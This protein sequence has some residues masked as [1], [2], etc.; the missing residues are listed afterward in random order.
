MAE[1]IYKSSLQAR[2]FYWEA[3][4]NMMQDQPLFG[5]GMDGFGDWYRRS[6]TQE[7]ADFNAGITADTAHSIPLDIG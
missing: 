6:R 3:A 4:L 1:V 5:V 2:S 7:I